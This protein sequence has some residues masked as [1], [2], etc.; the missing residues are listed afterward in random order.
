MKLTYPPDA[1]F[2]VD[3]IDASHPTMRTLT[4]PMPYEGTYPDYVYLTVNLAAA[5]GGSCVA[6]TNATDGGLSTPVADVGALYVRS[7]GSGRIAH[8]NATQILSHDEDRP[9]PTDTQYSQLV[10]NIVWWAAGGE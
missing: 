1:P 8:L 7:Y 9:S 4:N 6:T 10:R 3:I 2:A 5:N